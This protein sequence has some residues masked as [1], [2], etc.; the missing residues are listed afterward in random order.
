MD[1]LLSKLRQAVAN[2]QSGGPAVH[3]VR[4]ASLSFS[5]YRWVLLAVALVGFY[6]VFIVS[7]RYVTEARVYVK[8]ADTGAAVMP[9]LQLLAGGQG[10]SQDG[11]LVNAYFQS[12][13]LMERLEQDTGFTQHFAESGADWFSR[14]SRNASTESKLDYFKSRLSASLHPDSGIIIIRGQGFTPE[15]ALEFV[16]AALKAG[17]EFINNTGQQIAKEEIAFVEKEVER[18]RDNLNDVRGKL[19]TFQ[20]ENG[21]LSAEATGVSMQKLVSEMEAD[22]VR[23]RTE[24]KVLSSY[25]NETATEL[26]TVRSRQTALEEQLVQERER[27]ASQDGIS[28]NDVHAR[29]QELEMELKFATDLY[30]TTLVSLERARV[31]S[32]HKLKHLVVV[33]APSLA[34]KAEYP[35]KLYDLA[36][37]FIALT[38]A[39]G[40]ITMILATI[41]EHRDV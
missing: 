10:N 28:I 9:Q 23:L 15:Y 6:Y 33:Q 1:K 8:S 13:D 21:L 19:L 18:S 30:K 11:M 17:E 5:T 31:E 20:N 2:R 41:R 26:V 40:I 3:D 38:L 29:Y 22:L 25:L 16:Q 32:Y 34:D 37:L 36:T 39:Y 24:E 35:R 4:T 27:L 14:L 7:D 12:R